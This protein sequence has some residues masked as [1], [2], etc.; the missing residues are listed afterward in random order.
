[1]NTTAI[2]RASKHLKTN[3][4]GGLILSDYTRQ[5]ITII[6]YNIIGALINLCGTVA[7]ILNIATFIRQ[8]FADSMTVSLMGLALSD[9]GCLITLQWLNLCFNPLFRYAPGLPFESFE[10][11]YL[12]AGWPH[13]CFAR[14]T[15]LITAYI[16]ME[17]CL[18][19]AMPL[20]VKMLITP[21]RTSIVITAIF[22]LV[23]CSAAPV[24][25]VI[26][27]DWKFYPERNKTLLGVV[28]APNRAEVETVAF[29]FNNLYGYIAM[30][31]V[32]IFTIILVINLKSN[33]K[34]RQ[35]TSTASSSE[36]KNEATTRDKRVVKM[37]VTISTMFVVCFF[38]ITAVVVGTMV[39]PGFGK[40][41]R[42]RNIYHSICSLCYAMETVN[43]A[44]N[45]PIYMKMSSRF[46]VAFNTLWCKPC[47]GDI[48]SGMKKS[49]E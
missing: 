14:V 46:R 3:L 2:L 48:D 30:I 49:G 17:R 26:L 11:E 24:F 19:I 35:G 42:Y 43:A 13:V 32:T 41:G 31:S 33:S 27:A 23:F 38:P 37:V 28:F 8:G 16:T 22:I 39:E 4:E 1:M 20:K 21:K 36:S 44:A 45:F 18:C 12:T 29:A 10:L 47:G 34:W 40:G 7:N 5:I 6:N 25:T 15:G 9:L